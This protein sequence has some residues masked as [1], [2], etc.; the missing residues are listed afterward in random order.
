MR[1]R[2]S[3]RLHLPWVLGLLAL[4]ATPGI[5]AAQSV[6]GISVGRFFVRSADARDA[7][8][9]L[10]AGQTFRTFDIGDFDGVTIGGEWHLVVND[11]IEGGVGVDF[12][13][14]T[15]AARDTSFPN[16]VV[17]LETRATSLGFSARLFPMTRLGAL[18][19]YFGGG[20]GI[21]FWRY[22]EEGD[23]VTAASGA[24]VQASITDQGVAVGPVL[25]AGVRIPLGDQIR[26]GGELRHRIGTAK[27]NAGPFFAGT[28]LDLGGVTTVLTLQVGL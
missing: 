20:A 2:P 9:V 28:T 12:Y 27:L 15:V 10:R 5:A 23:F 26:L 21:H 7:T 16:A 6:L 17:D 11:Y 1:T 24:T 22:V 4:L 14:R 8:D 19:P 13:Q 3:T 18:Q 25:L